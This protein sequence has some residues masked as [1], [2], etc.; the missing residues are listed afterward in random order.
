M[1]RRLI[2]AIVITNGAFYVAFDSFMNATQNS[3]IRKTT[4]IE[5]AYNFSLVSD[6]IQVMRRS[7]KKIKDYYVFDTF[8][9]HILWK[10]MTQEEI[11]QAQEDKLYK[12]QIKRDINGKIKRKI[13]SQDTRKIIYNRAGGRCELCGRKLLLEDATLDHVIPLSKG[14]IDD[15]ENLACVCFEDNQFKNNILPEDFLERI[16]KIFMYQMEKKQKN[17]LKWKIVHRL[18]NRMV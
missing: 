8:T 14:G 4:N 13:Y 12:T 17:S 15:V 10:R 16:T 3:G 11:I 6:A 9:N 1:E 2:M 18:L 7:T 5:E